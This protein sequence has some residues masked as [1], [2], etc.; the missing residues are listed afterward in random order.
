MKHRSPPIDAVLSAVFQS[1]L[2]VCLVLGMAS[3]AALA[4]SDPEDSYRDASTFADARDSRQMSHIELIF[5]ESRCIRGLGPEG[6]TKVKESMKT[7]DED[8]AAQPIP[9]CGAVVSFYKLE[10]PPEEWEEDSASFYKFEE[11]PEEWEE[12]PIVEPACVPVRLVVF[13][14]ACRQP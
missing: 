10:E 9:E 4:I 6:L 1:S 14:R 13:N 8:S 3:Q 2:L 11:P 5:T 12:D 7:W